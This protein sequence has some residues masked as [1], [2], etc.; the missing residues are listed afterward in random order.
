M[1]CRPTRPSLSPWAR[2]PARAAGVAGPLR[3]EGTLAYEGAN[4]GELAAIRRLAAT[5]RPVVVLIHLDRRRCWSEFIDDV[6][7]VVAHYGA[8]DAALVTCCCWAARPQGRLPFNLARSMAAVRARRGDT[9][10]TTPTRCCRS[11][12]G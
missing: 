11:G 6:A 10:T 7:A 2:R 1:R 9:P 4:A 3:H 8:D 12:S 5:G